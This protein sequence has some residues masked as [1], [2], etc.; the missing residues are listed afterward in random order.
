VNWRKSATGLHLL[1]SFRQLGPSLLGKALDNRLGVATLIELVKHA[2]AISNCWLLLPFRKRSACAA[3]GW[4]HSVSTLTWRS[5]SI[6]PLPM[7]C[8]P[9]MGLENTRYNTRLDAGPAIY[10]A[11][12]RTL[13]DPRLIRHLL[14][15]A[16]KN[17]IP[18]QVGSR[19]AA[20]PMR[21]PFI[22]RRLVS[23]PYPFQCRGATP[24]LRQAY[25]AWMIG[26]IPWRSCIL[27]CAI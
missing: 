8:P 13:S 11:D 19:A 12:S 25:P 23:P 17:G 3:P 4:R 6:R 5:R 1:P 7:T 26:R 15:T 20:A 21:A 24:I 27:L 22:W 9:G 18:V 16:E 10:V 14:E 2:P